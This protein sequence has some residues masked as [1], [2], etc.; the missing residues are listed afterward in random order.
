MR[1]L[2]LIACLLLGAALP[3]AGQGGFTT[4]SG[5]IV[6]AVDGLTWSCGTITAQL[7]TAG[8]VSPTLNGGGFSTSVS[9]VTLGCP[10]SPGTGAPGSFTMRLADSGQISPSTTTWQFTVNMTPGI[11]PPAGTGPQSFTYTTAINCST[12]TPS[13]CTANAMSIS[14]QLSALAPKLSNSASSGGGSFS[15]I[16]AG[17]NTNPLVIGSGGSLSATGSGTII[18]TNG[19]SQVTTL[20]ALPCTNNTLVQSTVAPFSIFNCIGGVWLQE[21]ANGTVLE[22]SYGVRAD[23]ILINA[24]NQFTI[25]SGSSNFTVTGGPGLLSSDVGKAIFATTWGGSDTATGASCMTTASPTTIATVT[26]ST[27]GTLSQ[28]ATGSC[29]TTDSNTGVLFYGH[30]DTAARALA[31]AAAFDGPVCL[32]EYVP[33]GLSLQTTGQWN[34]SACPGTGVGNTNSHYAS[35]GGVAPGN[36][37]VIVIPPWFTVSSCTGNADSISTDCFG[38]APA[39][40]FTNLSFNGFGDTSITW[41]GKHF[42]DTTTDSVFQNDIFELL[43]GA[44]GNALAGFLI[45][46]GTHAISNVIVDQFGDAGPVTVNFVNAQA[47]TLFSGNTAGA[48]GI[49]VLLNSGAVLQCFTCAYFATNGN[50]SWVNGTGT[51]VFYDYNGFY[52]NGNTSSSADVFMQGSSRAYLYGINATNTGNTVSEVIATQG[53]AQAYLMAGSKVQGGATGAVWVCASTSV[54][55]D[56]GSNSETGTQG[57][58]PTCVMTT[59]GGTGPAC[60][61]IAGSTPT[62]GTIRMTPGTAPSATGTTTL[63]FGITLIG[64]TGT[65][66]TCQFNYANTGTGTWTAASPAILTTRSSTAPVFSWTATI[67]AASTYDVDYH[68]DKR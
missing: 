63:T 44:S 49:P 64:S 61:L 10:T 4:V 6:G 59:G 66:P 45:T 9:P 26:S 65:T 22:Q 55:N 12:N 33:Q 18:A 40:G 20:P 57:L 62:Q 56:D 28:N 36:L 19:I 2:F 53:T 1:R 37:S 14:V 67:I 46:G 54:C 13:T 41:G 30:D 24:G 5:T 8:G 27:T 50:G 31:K 29:G 16:T 32:L 47:T 51:S 68:C 60:A 48:T 43:A 17:T 23:G 38:S 21:N 58:A 42:L 52:L 39:S 15:T 34:T 3:A 11:A 7:I 25:T 35:V